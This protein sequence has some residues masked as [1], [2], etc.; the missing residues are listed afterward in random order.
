MTR[1]VS[2]TN[3]VILHTHVIALSLAREQSKNRERTRR[4]DFFHSL[5]GP[6]RLKVFHVKNRAPRCHKAELLLDK[7]AG[8]CVVLD[9]SSQNKQKNKSFVSLQH[10]GRLNLYDAATRSF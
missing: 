2:E 4:P 6:R 8:A 5:I 9:A 10:T 3:D 1:V 7:Q